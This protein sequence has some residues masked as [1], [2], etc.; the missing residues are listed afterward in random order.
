M[1]LGGGTWEAG[2][3]CSQVTSE[4]PV[5]ERGQPSLPPVQ[6]EKFPLVAAASV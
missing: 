3:V 2:G 6:G 5:G 4:I 1:D